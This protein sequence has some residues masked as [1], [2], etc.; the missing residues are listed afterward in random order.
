M[1]RPTKNS[2]HLWVFRCVALKK[3]EKSEEKSLSTK[4][5]LQRNK[6]SNRTATASF[7]DVSKQTD[8]KTLGSACVLRWAVDQ[9]AGENHIARLAPRGAALT[10]SEHNWNVL[11]KILQL[12]NKN[13]ESVALCEDRPSFWESQT[14]YGFLNYRRAGSSDTAGLTKFK[15][16]SGQSQSSVTVKWI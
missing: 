13:T 9:R 2:I 3:W 5:E 7:T 8:W 10:F 12:W 16:P 14:F 6:P 1:W 11:L 15:N 4:L